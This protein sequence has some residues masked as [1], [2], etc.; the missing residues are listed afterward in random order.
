MSLVVA[1]ASSGLPNADLQFVQASLVWCTLGH[2]QRRPA[3]DLCSCLPQVAFR[4]GK[5]ATFLYDPYYLSEVG[6]FLLASQSLGHVPHQA[7]VSVQPS[8]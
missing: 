6:G 5:R 2:V 1:A 8:G 4:H 7:R 3:L